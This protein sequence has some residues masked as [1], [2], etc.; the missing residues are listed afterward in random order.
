MLPGGQGLRQAAVKGVLLDLGAILVNTG[1]EGFLGEG[2]GTREG[3]LII[4]LAARLKGLF[5]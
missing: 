1:V 2:V 4:E 5:V 3:Q